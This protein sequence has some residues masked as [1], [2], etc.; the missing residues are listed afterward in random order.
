MEG[1]GPKASSLFLFMNNPRYTPRGEPWRTCDKCGFDF[2][3]SQGGMQ[4]GKWYCYHSCFDD[5][6]NKRI[7]PAPSPQKNNEQVIR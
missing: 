2:A 1:R 5:L 6:D 4:E 3:T 7:N